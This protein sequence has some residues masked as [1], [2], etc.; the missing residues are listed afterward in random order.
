MQREIDGVNGA[1]FP[2]L[3]PEDA[4]LIKQ[5]LADALAHGCMPPPCPVTGEGTADLAMVRRLAAAFSEVN[6]LA[7]IL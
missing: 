3:T 2:G 6:R 4:Q 7:S 5:A 1:A